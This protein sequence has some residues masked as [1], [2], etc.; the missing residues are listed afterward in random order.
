MLYYSSLFFHGGCSSVGRAEDCGSSGP[1]FESQLPHPRLDSLLMGGVSMELKFQ[2][3]PKVELQYG[4]LQ[5]RDEWISWTK[6]I[7]ETLIDSLE[8]C[9][10]IDREVFVEKTAKRLF[11]EISDCGFKEGYES[12]DYDRSENDGYF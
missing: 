7:L 9:Y 10:E 12:A 1:G 2:K 8:F 6:T 11:N 4:S 3:S 5:N